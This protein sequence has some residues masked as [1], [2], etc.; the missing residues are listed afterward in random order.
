M[1]RR[2]N[3]RNSQRR[4][5]R[6]NGQR[7]PGVRN[8]VTNYKF[9]EIIDPNIL[10]G[11][12][13]SSVAHV[14]II[15]TLFPWLVQSAGQFSK[16]TLKKVVFT[17]LPAGSMTYTGQIVGAFTYDS[18]ENPPASFAQLCQTARHRV[19][20]VHQAQSWTLD[21]GSLGKTIYPVITH[22][23]LVGMTESERLPYL[24]AIF[25]YANTSPN[26]QQIGMLQVTYSIDF[27]APVFLESGNSPGL[28]TWSS[29]EPTTGAAEND[30]APIDDSHQPAN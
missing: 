19:R 1:A 30:S 15:P 4:P 8:P 26:T 13:G 7:R 28:V 22:A 12:S 24:P 11:T 23:A 29:L 21:V 2:N 16:Y 10:G 20:T 14:N 9:S 27:S 18:F 17:F 5:A 6:G 25:H 3:P